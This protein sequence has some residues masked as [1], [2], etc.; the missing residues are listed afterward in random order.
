MKTAKYLAGALCLLFLFLTVG[1][2]LLSSNM[3]GHYKGM[4]ATD[5][6]NTALW[7]EKKDAWIPLGET[8]LFLY[9]FLC[10]V[11]CFSVILLADWLIKRKNKKE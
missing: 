10:S 4:M 9:G 1:A 2:S 5:P 7:L 11:G 8:F 3:Q 6:Q